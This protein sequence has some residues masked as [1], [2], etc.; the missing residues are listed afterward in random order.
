ML[1]SK[2]YEMEKD[3]ILNCWIVWEVHRNYK[4]EVF[5]SKLKKDCKEWIRKKVK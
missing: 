3:K 5:R 1:A 2:K 4:V